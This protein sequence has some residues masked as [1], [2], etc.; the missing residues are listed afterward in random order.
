MWCGRLQIQY[1]SF[2]SSFTLPKFSPILTP[3]SLP[4]LFLPISVLTAS[5]ICSNIKCCTGIASKDGSKATHPFISSVSQLLS[6]VKHTEVLFFFLFFLPIFRA[7]TQ[8]ART[9][10]FKSERPIVGMWLLS[11]TVPEG[12]VLVSL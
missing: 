2:S 8:L 6:K 7:F 11:N 12:S 5:T 3:C 9:L 10:L 1:L 4:L